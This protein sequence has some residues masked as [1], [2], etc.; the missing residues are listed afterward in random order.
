MSSR[1]RGQPSWRHESARPHEGS[2]RDVSLPS[3]LKIHRG[4]RQIVLAALMEQKMGQ[5]ETQDLHYGLDLMLDCM[6]ELLYRVKELEAKAEPKSKTKNKAKKP[7][8][9]K[10]KS[11]TR[12]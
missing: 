4:A 6:G 9:R 3:I 12:S 10:P 5:A 11:R 8:K 2:L 1:T 7:G